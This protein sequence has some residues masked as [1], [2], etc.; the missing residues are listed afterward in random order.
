MLLC[1]TDPCQQPE[2][3]CWTNVR[4][5]NSHYLKGAWV[6]FCSLRS[7]EMTGNWP[8]GHMGLILCCHPHGN[9]PRTV[10]LGIV[11]EWYREC[12]SHKSTQSFKVYSS[13]IQQWP[14]WALR[15]AWFQFKRR[16]HSI[17]MHKWKSLCLCKK[18]PIRHLWLKAE[19]D[20]NMQ[21]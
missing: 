14:L 7:N 20:L 16:K 1:I 15:C 2:R 13:E 5:I 11:S 21:H 19:M 3:F 9:W 18:V 6:E 4:S 12:M 10:L 8:S 17:S